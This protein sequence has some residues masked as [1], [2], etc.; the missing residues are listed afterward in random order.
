MFT[1]SFVSLMFLRCVDF[2]AVCCY[3][4]FVVYWYVN[5]RFVAN[6]IDGWCCDFWLVATF[7]VLVVL[8]C[9]SLLLML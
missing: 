8:T 4:R 9:V 5:L 7:S 3:L 2:I 1:G 6:L